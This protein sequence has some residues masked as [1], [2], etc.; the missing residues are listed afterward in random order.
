MVDFKALAERERAIRR[1]RE[2]V[3][4]VDEGHCIRPLFQSQDIKLLLAEYDRLQRLR[5]NNL[6]SR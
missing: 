4:A 1:L 6:N 2:A 5:L 3:K